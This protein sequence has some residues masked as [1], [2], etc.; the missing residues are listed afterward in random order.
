MNASTRKKEK[1]VV[2]NPSQICHYWSGTDFMI[3]NPCYLLFSW[4]KFTINRHIFEIFETFLENSILFWHVHI[5]THTHTHSL[6]VREAE[7]HFGFPGQKLQCEEDIKEHKAINAH[8]KRG[9]K[10]KTAIRTWKANCEI[11]V[12]TCK[13][14]FQMYKADRGSPVA[15]TIRIVMRVKKGVNI[16]IALRYLSLEQFCRSGKALI[17]WHWCPNHTPGSYSRSEGG[18]KSM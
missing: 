10:K 15:A 4:I 3:Y 9:G 7:M 2:V 5:Y 6:G 11:A 14:I 13:S 1:R 17:Q 12:T 8:R 18:F 16:L